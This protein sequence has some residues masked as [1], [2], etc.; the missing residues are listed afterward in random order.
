MHNVTY[1]NINRRSKHE[2][3]NE[4]VVR[5]VEETKNQMFKCESIQTFDF[6]YIH[7][8]C[9]ISVNMLK[10]INQQLLKNFLLN[11]ALETRHWQ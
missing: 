8:F 4:K 2:R 5:V 7:S 1:I 3:N 9:Y 11:V 10:F 6:D